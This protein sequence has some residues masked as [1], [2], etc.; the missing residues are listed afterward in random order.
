MPLAIDNGVL[1]D[2]RRLAKPVY[3][4]VTEIFDELDAAMLAKKLDRR[5]VSRLTGSTKHG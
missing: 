4:R 2:L 3:S 5:E 1:K